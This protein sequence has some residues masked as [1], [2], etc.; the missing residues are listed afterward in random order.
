MIGLYDKI[1]S[2]K[3]RPKIVDI[4]EQAKLELGLT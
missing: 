4:E 2:I 3:S 1:V